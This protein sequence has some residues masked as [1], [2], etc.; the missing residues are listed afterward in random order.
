MHLT[1]Q[2]FS[3]IAVAGLTIISAALVVTLRNIFH[4][5]LF[6]ALAFLG[7]A[8]IYLL[9]SADFM[10]AAQVLIYIGAIVVLMMFALMMTHRVM[11]TNVIQTLGQWW[12]APFP[13]A[14]GIFFALFRVLIRYDFKLK[15]VPAAEPTTG[16]IGTQLLTRYVLPFELASIVLLVAMVGAIILAKED[17]PDDSP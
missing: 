11:S 8:G 3:F 17:K 7:V 1:L 10:A 16:I 2:Q 4:C 14:A 13:I 12:L 15:G 5:L 9:L 6:L